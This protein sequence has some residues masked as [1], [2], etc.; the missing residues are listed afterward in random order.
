MNVL[1]GWAV[2]SWLQALIPSL[3]KKDLPPSR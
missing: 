3:S 1:T 2:Q